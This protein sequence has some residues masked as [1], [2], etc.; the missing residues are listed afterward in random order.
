MANKNNIS[1]LGSLSRVETP[2]VKVQIGDYV[3]GIYD[4]QSS[5]KYES[6]VNLLY[7]E[8]KIVYP[9]YIQGLQVKKIN[10]QVNTYTLS[11]RY[12]ITDGSDPNFFSKVFSSVSRTRKI[13]FSYG[14]LSVPTFIYKN[15]E[16]VIIS[17]KES[18]SAMNSVIEYSLTAISSGYL[19]SGSRRDFQA[20]YCKPSDRIKW[21]LQN[22]N[23]FGLQDLFFG[24]RD[25]EKVITDGL[26]A[27]DDQPVQLE[28]KPNTSVFDYLLYLVGE[29]NSLQDNTNSTQLS[30]FYS[31]LV[32]D[33][34]SG[35]YDGPY[36]KVVKTDTSLEHPE[37]YVI[38]IGYPS[39][40][41]VTNFTID[42]DESY[43]ILYDYTEELVP[44]TYVRRINNQGEIEEVYSPI[45]SSGNSMFETH[46]TD[47][48][49]WSKITQFP[50]RASLTLKGL[51]RPAILMEYVRLNVYFYGKKH[52]SSGLYIITQQQDSVGFDGFKTTLTLQKVA[53]D[54]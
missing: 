43:S 38:D 48:I 49:W 52:V 6:N 39:E 15:E 24:M 26:I 40:N 9:N 11:I 7:K 18:V 3:F 28:Y 1:L 50:I 2:F 27:S 44:D 29:M 41:I 36:F 37:A 34:V 33:D 17:V 21:L 45:I 51:L 12:P 47:K 22:N 46:N 20:I 54:E 19:S 4:K 25:Y 10:G 13:V 31:L 23:E 8:E 30:A 14:D 32:Y 5:S 42:N 35:V 16:A 53:G